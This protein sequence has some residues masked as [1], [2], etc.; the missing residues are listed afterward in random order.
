MV[1]IKMMFKPMIGNALH[2]CNCHGTG[3]N[4]DWTSAEGGDE[5]TTPAGD[6]IKWV[7][8]FFVWCICLYVLVYA[9]LFVFASGPVQKEKTNNQLL[10]DIKYVFVFVFW[11]IGLCVFDCSCLCEKKEA[12]K[13]LLLNLE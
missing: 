5:Q 7:F 6:T 3:C 13:Q 2:Y 12:N 9:R 8:V 11:S 4:K 1:K 10:L